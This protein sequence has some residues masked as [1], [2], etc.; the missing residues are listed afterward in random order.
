MYA[1]AHNPSLGDNEVFERYA[2]KQAL[3]LDAADY[4]R[5][6]E[7]HGPKTRSAYSARIA[8]LEQSVTDLKAVNS[9]QSA[10][11]AKLTEE[12]E[13]LSTENAEFRQK[14]KTALGREGKAEKRENDRIPFWRVAAPLVNRLIAEAESDTKY[15]RRQIQEAFQQELESLPELKPAIQKLLHT[16]KKERENMPFSLDGWGMKAIRSA[17]GDLA[18]KDPGATPKAD[19]Y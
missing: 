2:G 16:A 11:I 8:E 19:K 14:L 3:C 9:I 1:F 6:L 7:E 17:L 12:K 10:D 15:S 13:T 5:L 4:E 18:K